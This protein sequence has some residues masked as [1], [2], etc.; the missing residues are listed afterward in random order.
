MTL[1]IDFDEPH[2]H[3]H[4]SDIFKMIDD[5][6]LS[7]VKARSKSIFEVIGH[8]EAK[9]HGMSFKTSTFMKWGNGLY[10]RYYWWMYCFRIIKY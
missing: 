2:H 5:S 10:Y 6:A 8:A 4:A 1:N 3:R 9:I 7:R